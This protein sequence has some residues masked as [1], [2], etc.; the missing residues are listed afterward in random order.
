MDAELAALAATGATTLVSLMVTDSWTHARALVGRFFSRSEADSTAIADLDSSRTQM[1]G[2]AAPENTTREL[3]EQ[4]HA[5][6]YHLMQAGLA[7]RSE[8]QDLLASLQRLATV[9]DAQPG[10]VHN[11]IG[12][13]VQHGP[14]IQTGRITGLTF[15]AHSPATLAEE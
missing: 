6:M 10:S 12:G 1:L 8:L 15:H 5:R 3:T 11:E 14:V 7:S 13:G 4:W 2:A 9:P